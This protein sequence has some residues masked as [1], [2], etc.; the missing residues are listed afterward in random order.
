MIDLMVRR[1]FH[2][3]VSNHDARD[4]SSFETPRKNA[5]PQDEELVR[6]E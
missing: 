2:S 1:R 3:A 4:F 5:S 6:T